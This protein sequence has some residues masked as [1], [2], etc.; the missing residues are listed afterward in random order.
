MNMIRKLAVVTLLLLTAS[1]A[2]AAI[3]KHWNAGGTST[4]MNWNLGANWD[5]SLAP[6]SISQVY[7]ENSTTTNGVTNVIGAINNIVSVNQVVQQANYNAFWNFYSAGLNGVPPAVSNPP[8][9]YGTYIPA[10]VTLT[11]SNTTAG[12]VNNP[13]L[14][15]GDFPDIG[16]YFFSPGSWAYTTVTG[17][18]SMSI[19]APK[20]FI[21]VG[22][23]Q[24]ANGVAVMDMS[25]LP[26]LNASVGM[27]RVG[28]LNQPV[29]VDGKTNFGYNG[30][31]W[32]P[33]TNIVT[34]YGWSGG[35]G[36][37][38]VIDVD[39]SQ[40][41][42]KYGNFSASTLV[43]VAQG[44]YQGPV[45]V[46]GVSN[47]FNT[48]GF[49]VGG[50]GGYSSGCLFTNAPYNPNNYF[51][52]RGTNG[53][54]PVPI[55]SIGDLSAD[56]TSYSPTWRL[57]TGQ[58]QSTPPT[59][60]LSGGYA[61]IAADAIYL[62]RSCQSNTPTGFGGTTASTAYGRML[63]GNGVVTATNL[64]LGHKILGGTN[65]SSPSG[66]LRLDTTKMTVFNN[67]Y[68][69][70]RTNGAGAA[71][72]ATMVSTNGA[73][74]TVA[75]NL[76]QGTG[77][78]GGFFG[79]SQSS[80]VV[81]GSTNY[82]GGMIVTN[83]Q[84]V[85]T[86]TNGGLLNVSNSI[87]GYGGSQTINLEPSLDGSKVSTMYVNGDVTIGQLTGA[88]NLNS[89]GTLT[90]SNQNNGINIGWFAGQKATISIG[91]NLNLANVTNLTFDLSGNNTTGSGVNDYIS[92]P[93]LLSYRTGTPMT[94]QLNYSNGLA[95]GAY[96]LMSYGSTNGGLQPTNLFPIIT[97]ANIYVTNDNTAKQ[98]QLVA[99]GF[100]N[101]ATLYWV[102]VMNTNGSFWTIG[103]NF[104]LPGSPMF[105]TNLTAGADVFK[106][107]DNAVF[108]ESLVATNFV[109]ANQ[110]IQIGTGG[111]TFNI[112]NIGFTNVSGSVIYGQGGL[113][114]N[115]TTDGSGSGWLT[116]ASANDFLGPVQLKGGLT[117]IGSAQA[118]G[119]QASQTGTVSVASGAALTFGGATAIGTFGN[120]S[121]SI[122]PIYT[123]SARKWTIAGTGMN[124]S[125]VIWSTNNAQNKLFN[126]G[127][128][129]GDNAMVNATNPS[130]TIAGSSSSLGFYGIPNIGVFISSNNFGVSPAILD[131]NGKTLTINSVAAN[132]IQSGTTFT[133]TNPF[134]IAGMKVANTGV[135]GGIDLASGT[136]QLGDSDGA[137][138]AF[139]DSSATITMEN[140]TI[141]RL[142]A[143][144]FGQG[145]TGYV[146]APLIL[147][148][149]GMIFG[150]DR[151]LLD[152]V[153]RHTL[154]NFGN[155]ITINS[156]GVL[157]VSNYAPSTS[158]SSGNDPLAA[159]LVLNGAIGQGAPGASLVKGGQ[160]RLWLGASET[161]TGP[162]YINDGILV[163]SNNQA[164]TFAS[165]L[166]YFN[167]SQTGTTNNWLD[168]SG[169]PNGLVLTQPF[170][171]PNLING[172]LV[173]SNGCVMGN[174]ALTTTINGSLTVENNA[175]V[176]PGTTFDTGTIIVT[177]N[178]VLS[179]DGSN[180]NF[181]MNVGPSTNKSDQIYVQGDLIISNNTMNIF[182]IDTL[183]G[184]AATS[185]NN[186]LIQYT[187]HLRGGG[188]LANLTNINVNSRFYVQFVDPTLTTNANG[189]GGFLAVYLVTNPAVLTWKGWD[190][191]HG[192]T[193]WNVKGATSLGTTNWS[194]TNGSPDFF[195][196]GDRVNFDD[197]GL[198]Y[199][200]YMTNTVGPDT[201]TF[202][203]NNSGHQ[204]TFSGPGAILA[205]SLTNNGSQGVVIA[206]NATNN[207]WV[208]LGL[209]NAVSSTTTFNQPSNATVTADLVGPG[210]FVKAGANTLTVNAQDPDTFT[211]NF[212]VNSGMV[213]PAAN[214]VTNTFGNINGQPR[215]TVN[216]GVFD[217]NGSVGDKEKITV[218]GSGPILQIVSYT[219][220][221]VY[222]SNNFANTR[223][224]VG[225]NVFTV[226]NRLGALDNNGAR[227]TRA[228]N[229]VTLSGDTVMGANS[230]AWYVTSLDVNGLAPGFFN[231]NN[232]DL[233]KVGS[234]DLWLMPGTN[235]TL[236][237]IVVAP[238]GGKL[239]FADPSSAIN[240]SL[241][242]AG[243]VTVCSNAM[244]GF[245]NSCNISGKPMIIQ[246]GGAI[247]TTGGSNSFNGNITISNGVTWL[248]AVQANAEI[249]AI[250]TSSNSAAQTLLTGTNC[251][252]YFDPNATLTLSGNISGPGTLTVDAIQS[253]TNKYGTE[254]AL[255]LS[256]TNSY[257]GGTVIKEGQLTITKNDSF[258]QNTNII[259]YGHVSANMS[260]WPRLYIDGNLSTPA[261][262]GALLYA[263]GD[264]SA[265][266]YDNDIVKYSI[267][268]A[269]QIGGNGA[270]WNGPIT[271][272]GSPTNTT[273]SSIMSVVSFNTG[274]NGMT[275]NGPIDG[276]AFQGS[277]LR[278]KFFVHNGN[279]NYGNGGVALSGISANPTNGAGPGITFNGPLNL[280][281]S[282]RSSEW[283][284]FTLMPKITFA[285]NGNNWD[286]LSIQR[287]MM[288]FGAANA[289]PIAP[290]QFGSGFPGADHRTIFDLNGHNQSMNWL[291]GAV[292]DEACWIGNGSNATSDA[293]LTY[294]GYSTNMTG[295]GSLTQTNIWNY[296]IVDSLFTNA[297]PWK[298]LLNVTGGYLQLSAPDAGSGWT[299]T[300]NQFIYGSGKPNFSMIPFTGATTVSGGTL[301]VAEDLKSASITVNGTGILRGLG[302]SVGPVMVTG[303]GTL[304]PGSGLG[305][306]PNVA[307]PLL[308]NTIP[309]NTIGT[310]T[311]SNTVTFA[312][313]G[314]GMF[315]V[316]NAYGA[317]DQLVA[318]NI[319]FGGALTVINASFD[320]VF[321]AFTNTQA[322]PLFSAGTYAGTVPTVLPA[323]P[324]PGL[325]WN[326]STLMTD[327]NV[328]VSQVTTNIPPMLARTV[329]GSGSSQTMTL[330]WPQN[331]GGY[332]LQVQTNALNVGL[333]PNAWVDWNNS[334]NVLSI[335]IPTTN[336]PTV[337]FRLV[338]P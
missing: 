254:G 223:Y 153:G 57:L 50:A 5:D 284:A 286:Q 157:T 261:N 296:F 164:F 226:T 56:V 282:V 219:N 222:T 147:N 59:L 49:T 100:N 19:T 126:S 242:S 288:V 35:S 3:I 201:M 304:A 173:V 212:M 258:V 298:T 139:V 1:F 161:Y 270:T 75:G 264:G 311:V 197:N 305:L 321:Y 92:V 237:N 34:A 89:T 210:T 169:S 76:L 41:G 103:T 308:S 99:N 293:V 31:F 155:S 116:L 104:T 15:G 273:S 137:G 115:G 207:Y 327:G 149:N 140:N 40:N 220:T 93:G 240:T 17:S 111:M 62:G 27:V 317:N 315:N 166:L 216:G 248:G 322:I 265:P 232:H 180:T 236:G 200:I 123:E 14:T 125:G 233:N 179:G 148:G 312:A 102:G 184:F 196:N 313:T 335:T 55:L 127:I 277:S 287:G 230:N 183:G 97:R 154:W 234:S 191:V 26:N 320:P 252:V 43:P 324:A 190:N 255:T 20:S 303:G 16:N 6:I 251:F 88:G 160:G 278:T 177:N 68:W 231:G 24:G 239:I 105:W 186:I 218:T 48:V 107:F 211:G 86:V 120:G 47:V 129:L 82:F 72:G 36:P 146:N 67:L 121:A 250:G 260:G 221:Y 53:T 77:N 44:P 52:L 110:P 12:G 276:S 297:V 158:L 165:S 243:I 300:G 95:T 181:F 274:T 144:S 132:L 32:L 133:Q 8:A 280:N 229:N 330:S 215:V 199:S 143:V 29:N 238:N 37:G 241:G 74:L 168:C 113:T 70:D 272:Q 131:L 318:T 172:N 94:L 246:G 289:L 227:Q 224:T 167:Q 281:G 194:N 2:N 263:D 171:P 128:T 323:A 156:G 80:I 109:K 328:R 23:S 108:D 202:N 117:A 188:G 249:A 319:I 9:V 13:V 136:L 90:I 204:Y 28:A 292:G 309:T 203:N 7:F 61:D 25:G 267:W 334:S 208:G 316:D 329:Q 30:V 193:N 96:V 235:L 295:G 259:L 299:D 122:N 195:G 84:F 198:T 213:R 85:V 290:I 33:K 118:F 106:Q 217:I 18:G 310:F 307:N 138:A 225:V 66:F 338:Y 142:R 301:D 314:N 332:R 45:M 262:V 150:S 244:V 130:G 337:F 275:F 209:Y 294:V 306:I 162:T 325:V 206:N 159:T 11:L 170:I 176:T 151:S 114:R 269:C 253:I 257:T 145:Q 69:L 112:T 187:G 141:L 124:N 175:Q 192:N 185:T 98:L 38:V 54:S 73:V 4:N 51:K 331:Y 63:L 247:F 245:G 10:T 65:A 91:N 71:G 285:T 228:L 134:I 163:V 279:T 78:G 79:T 152:T 22:G 214:S 83:Q 39:M 60:D 205:G 81:D 326:T 64:Y 271:I 336:N 333:K 101:C 119:I 178:L 21:F 182:S 256:G 58:F 189:I 302:S 135:G 266:L 291:V 283:N 268:G 87:L 42:G 174:G 46:L